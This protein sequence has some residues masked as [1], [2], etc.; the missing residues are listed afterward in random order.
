MKWRRDRRTI[1]VHFPVGLFV[2]WLMAQSAVFGGFLFAG[3]MTYEVVED[4]RIKDR[5]F[6]DIFGFLVGFGL[7]AALL[8]RFQIF[9]C[10]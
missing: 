4:W 7:A 2:A 5:G 8:V 1:L 9:P 3:F 10:N 6:R